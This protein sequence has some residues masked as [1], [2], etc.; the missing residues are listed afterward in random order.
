MSRTKMKLTFSNA[1]C[2]LDT[3]SANCKIKL[4][5]VTR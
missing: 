3:A 5:L 1:G 2:F 4:K